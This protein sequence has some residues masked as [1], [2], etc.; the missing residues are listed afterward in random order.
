MCIPDVGTTKSFLNQ[1]S[2]TALGLRSE[3]WCSEDLAALWNTPGIQ[4]LSPC[5]HCCLSCS[6]YSPPSLGTS[7]LSFALLLP[8]LASQEP[9]SCFSPFA[10]F[11]TWAAHCSSVIVIAPLLLPS[12]CY[13]LALTV[14]N[15]PGETT[16]GR[17]NAVT[18]QGR[19]Q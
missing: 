13:Q 6:L 4:G 14:E 17:P 5:P 15:R 18:D 8:A 2:V 3:I 1:V 16:M 11:A 12:L 19:V 7:L 10:L 9:L